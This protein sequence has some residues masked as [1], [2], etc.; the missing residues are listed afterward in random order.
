MA[1]AFALIMQ[2]GYASRWMSSSFWKV[3]VALLSTLLPWNLVTRY[4]IEG[5]EHML[6]EA[7]GDDWKAYTKE[8][9][10]RLVPYV[11]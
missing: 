6:S 11:W 4:R 1:F 8:V 10:Y 9:P 2:T 5:E 7:F 3:V